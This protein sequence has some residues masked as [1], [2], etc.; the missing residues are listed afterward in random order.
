VTGLEPA[1]AAALAGATA[2][3]VQ[4]SLL[5]RSARPGPGALFGVARIALV[6]SILFATA[7]AGH[8]LLGAAGWVAGLGTC[9]LLLYRRLR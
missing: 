8:P 5:V 3:A 7:R 2:G 4:A 1:I 6:G 9:G